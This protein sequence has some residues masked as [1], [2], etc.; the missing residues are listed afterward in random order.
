MECN[1]TVT[2]KVKSKVKPKT[3]NS[4]YPVWIYVLFY[5]LH[6]SDKE[7]E[8]LTYWSICTLGGI[9]WYTNI[10]QSKLLRGLNTFF[11]RNSSMLFKSGFWYFHIIWTESF[12]QCIDSKATLLILTLRLRLAFG[13]GSF[14]SLWIPFGNSQA[15]LDS[16]EGPVIMR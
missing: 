6:I 1:V 12:C 14:C 8:P 5:D 7:T 3:L 16:K 13:E 2:V 11:R 15:I 10:P 9:S 4:V